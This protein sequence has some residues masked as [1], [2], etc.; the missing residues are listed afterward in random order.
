[1]PYETRKIR[2]LREKVNQELDAAPPA[3]K[4]ESLP[5]RCAG[6]TARGHDF[7]MLGG[8]DVRIR[9][10]HWRNRTAAGKTWLAWQY[11]NS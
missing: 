4:A 1:M 2:S 8:E 7:I 3:I 10:R 6:V 5:S 11:Q 9:E